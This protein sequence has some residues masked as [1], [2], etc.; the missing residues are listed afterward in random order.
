M[1]KGIKREKGRPVGTTKDK[2]S[3]KTLRKKIRDYLKEKDIKVLIKI[4]HEQAK[5]GDKKMLQFLLDHSFGKPRQNVGLD[6]GKDG[7][8]IMT[9]SAM[10]DQLEKTKKLTKSNNGVFK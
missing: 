2:I 1:D 10:L 7:Q 8:P 9:M 6:G 5:A 4:A 3:T